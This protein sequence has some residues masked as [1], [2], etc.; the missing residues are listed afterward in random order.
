MNERSERITSYGVQSTHRRTGG[1][2]SH[3]TERQV[4]P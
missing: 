4:R 1:E 2:S 3:I